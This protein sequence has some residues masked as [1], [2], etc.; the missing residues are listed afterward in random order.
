MSEDEL[1]QLSPDEVVVQVRRLEV[2]LAA[3]L[4]RIAELEAELARRSGPPKTP[5]NS[6][7]PPSKGWKRKRPPA[8][9]RKL[10][11]PPGHPGHSRAR[12][13]PDEVRAYRPTHCRHCGEALPADRQ[14]L[15][16][17]RQ[18]VELPPVRSWVRSEERRVGKECR[19]RWSP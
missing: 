17:R 10:G 12:V 7:L 5:E 4:A 9:G 6:S 13:A 1:R 8:P 3:A 2:A 14:H 16:A 19:S 18:V 15:L 11:P